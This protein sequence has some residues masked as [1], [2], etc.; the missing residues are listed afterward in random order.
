MLKVSGLFELWSVVS[1]NICCSRVRTDVK[2][3]GVGRDGAKS[4]WPFEFEPKRS[5]AS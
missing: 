4:V 3:A 5:N 2:R 1:S